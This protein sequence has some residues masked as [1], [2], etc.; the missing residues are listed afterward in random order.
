MVPILMLATIA[1]SAVAITATNT[2][3]ASAADYLPPAS[4]L[5]GEWVISD[6]GERTKAQLAMAMGANGEALLTSWYWR[7]NIYR[8]LTR[9]DPASFSDETT[10]INV[11]VHRFA[12]ADG[13]SE[14]LDFWSN[15]ILELQGLQ[16][17]DAY[18]PGYR[19]RGLSGP[20]DGV[21]LYIL[22]VEDEKHILRIGG[23]SATGD[24]EP[25]VL[26]LVTK[27]L[28]KAHAS[29]VSRSESISAVQP[30]YY[31]TGQTVIVSS[32][33]AP[34]RAEPSS[35]SRAVTTVAAGDL[36]KSVDRNSVQADGLTWWN[37]Q[38]IE[39]G[40]IG[41]LADNAFSVVADGD[42]GCWTAE[43]TSM[44]DDAPSWTAPPAMVIDPEST[45]IATIST[46]E[47]KIILELDAANAPIATNNFICLANAGYYD[48]TMFHRISSDFLI[49]GGDRSGS[50]TGN[51]GY[52]IPSDPTTGEYPEGSIALANS[53]PDQN[54]SQFFI[55]VTDLTGK[56]PDDY[57][58]FGH[59]VAGQEI[60]SGISR[61][62]VDYNPRGELSQPVNLTMIDSI[63]IVQGEKIGPPLPPAATPNAIPA[64][65]PANAPDVTP[66]PD[67]SQAGI[68]HLEAKDIAF[69]PTELTINAADEP[70]TIRMEN[71]G[72]AL[73]DFTIDSLNISVTAQ[74]GETVDIVIPAGTAPGA[75]DVYC[76]VPGHKEA[77]MVGTLIVK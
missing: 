20:G 41:W 10:Y 72:A 48:G 50:G 64:A 42:A 71:T 67:P 19:A 55:A 2:R 25:T 39:D 3:T 75:Y 53:K 5:D 29:S 45:Y 34:M 74:P 8:D 17:T 62:A 77:G 4:M 37:V 22:Y 38:V 13:A 14:A 31:E 52:T 30:S 65:T 32:Q 44:I 21:N 49:Q 61:G 57:P 28:V 58:V 33:L 26:T 69:E 6:D 27:I 18:L 15:Q 47:G 68:L 76:N 23:S 16:N 1:G 54:G 60:V 43:Q 7:E 11:S 66:T 36:L 12:S 40:M 73:H 59:V 51:P 56:I 46:T 63:A 24:P 9:V 70:V 35:S